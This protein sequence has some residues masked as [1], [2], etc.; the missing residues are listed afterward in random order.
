M[1]G[2]VRMSQTNHNPRRWVDESGRVRVIEGRHPSYPMRL[3]FNVM[4]DDDWLGTFDTLDGAADAATRPGLPGPYAANGR[5][6]LLRV[7]DP[8]GPRGE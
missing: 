8:R 5:V 7:I 6:V 3:G 4:I 2:A 1:M